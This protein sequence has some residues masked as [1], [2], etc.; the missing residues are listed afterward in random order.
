[1]ST[2]KAAV[3]SAQA[4]SQAELEEELRQANEDFA[5]G[6]FVELTIEDLDR[7]TAEEQ[8]PWRASSG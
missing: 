4:T 8:W 5:N 7:C 1:M 2:L 6:D 3:P